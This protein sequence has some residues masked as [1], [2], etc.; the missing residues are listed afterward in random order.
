MIGCGHKKSSLSSTLTGVIL[1]S[2]AM[3]VSGSSVGDAFFT[4][5][6]VEYFM[7]T[8]MFCDLIT[9]ASSYLST[10]GAYDRSITFSRSAKAKKVWISS[11]Y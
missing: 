1:L 8:S 5:N 10:F 2:F 9:I 4:A 6:A 7:I 11:Q 3:L